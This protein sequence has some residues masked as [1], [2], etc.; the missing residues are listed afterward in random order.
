MT[1]FAKHM[2]SP[3][4]AKNPWANDV[5]GRR[6][7]AEQLTVALSTLTQPFVLGLHSEFGNGK[8]FFVERWRQELINAGDIAVY[9]NAWETDYAREPLIAF[10]AAIKRQLDGT[11]LA[12]LK[13]RGKL[14]R[15]LQGGLFSSQWYPA[16]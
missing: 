8:T 16:R 2:P 12:L 15:L 7:L 11:A 4:D 14:L 5:L 9:F 3:M 13:R 6:E 10:T 1:Q